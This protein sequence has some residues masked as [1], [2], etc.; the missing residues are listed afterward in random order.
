MATAKFAKHPSAATK[1]S[2]V[3]DIANPAT[4]GVIT[5]RL[6]ADDTDLIKPGRY[7][8][9]VETSYNFNGQITRERVMEG[10]LFLDASI[11]K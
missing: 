1:Y 8:Y 10:T 7:L 9:D 4:A 3:S 2:F 6:N 11:T 5:L